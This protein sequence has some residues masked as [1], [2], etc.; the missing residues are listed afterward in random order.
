MSGTAARAGR[1]AITGSSGLIGSAVS[2]SLAAAGYAAVRLVRRSARSADEVSWD[3]AEGIRQRAALEGLAGV[4]HLAGE[5]LAAGRWSEARKAQILNSRVQGTA[6]LC[7]ALAGL[8]RRPRALVSASAVGVYGN[9]GS[10][11][12]REDSDPGT[13][14]LAGVCRDWEA[15]TGAASAAGIRVVLARFGM[16]LSPKGGA[17]KTMLTPFRLGVGG[18]IGSGT[19]YVSWIAL[20]DVVGAI[21]HALRDERLSGPVN[22]VAPAPVTNADFARA[23]GRAVSRPAVLPLPAFAARLALGEMADELLLA[24]QRVLPARLEATGYRFLHSRLDQ[25]LQHVLRS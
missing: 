15:A 17:L 19:Q 13:G 2:R 10:E 4:V 3:P 23:L 20:D 14:F 5:N 6:A 22:V 12:L 11:V 16:V 7:A 1:V 25:A 18:R 8:T 24:S 21:L 9:R